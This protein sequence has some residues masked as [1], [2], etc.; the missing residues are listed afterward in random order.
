MDRGFV[1][2]LKSPNVEQRLIRNEARDVVVK[3]YE[4]DLLDYCFRCFFESFSMYVLD[5]DSKK[6]VFKV[7][8]ANKR[9]PI[10]FDVENLYHLFGLSKQSLRRAVIINDLLRDKLG[11]CPM[12]NGFKKH[13]AGIEMF[14]KL[15]DLFLDN[16][17]DI[18]LH[19]CN[20]INDSVD[21]LNWD[22]MAYKLFCFL[23]IGDLTCGD[24]IFYSYKD[25][26]LFERELISEIDGEKKVLLISYVP[27]GNG[28]SIYNPVSIRIV[29]KTMTRSYTFGRDAN[30]KRYALVKGL[31][32]GYSTIEKKEVC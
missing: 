23:N 24:T 17:E 12:D 22:K 20:P 31:K 32:K 26:L 14:S 29:P 6:Y 10:C 2:S 1:E 7:T 9:I 8:L 4:E 19:D 28:S 5:M 13:F 11:K 3:T 25:E 30:E 21:K 27:E 15:C 18:K 16:G